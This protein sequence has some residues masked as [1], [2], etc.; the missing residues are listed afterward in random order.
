MKEHLL[1]KYNFLKIYIYIYHLYVFIYEYMNLYICVY[2]EEI[3]LLNT[4]VSDEE[5]KIKQNKKKQ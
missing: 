1:E 2:F 5:K 3:Y 4:R